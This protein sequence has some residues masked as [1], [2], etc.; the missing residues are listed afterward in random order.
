MVIFSLNLKIVTHMIDKSPQCTY[1]MEAASPTSSIASEII[2]LMVMHLDKRDYQ[3]LSLRSR[4]I[5]T[6]LFSIQE[7]HLKDRDSYL[8]DVVEVW[9][10][11]FHTHQDLCKFQ[12]VEL[13]S[14][15]IFGMKILSNLLNCRRIKDVVR[16]DILES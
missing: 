11:R 2:V 4:Q 10:S 14:K 12:L 3:D 1:L 6:M 16:T 9:Q 5:R 8:L 15:Q 13:S 7:H